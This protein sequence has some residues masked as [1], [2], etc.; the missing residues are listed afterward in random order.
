MLWFTTLLKVLFYKESLLGCL[1]VQIFLCG[2]RTS[3]SKQDWIQKH[4]NDFDVGEEGVWLII[5]GQT[6]VICTYFL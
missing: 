1:K 2:L 5:K 4:R 6:G 3:W